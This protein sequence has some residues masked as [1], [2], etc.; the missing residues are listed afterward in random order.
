MSKRARLA[1]H[2]HRACVVDGARAAVGQLTCKTC[3][4]TMAAT[5]HEL[6]RQ[7]AELLA[8]HLGGA[9]NEKLSGTTEPPIPYRDPIGNERGRI[10]TALAGWAGG[11]ARATG[12]PRPVDRHPLATAGYLLDHHTWIQ[13]WAGVDRLA[14]DLTAR[15]DA[16]H[17]LLFPVGQ[18]RFTITMPD[19]TPARCLDCAGELVATIRH[20][21]D[22]LPSAITC[23]RC[24]LDIPASS[25]LTW[26][27]QTRRAMVSTGVMAADGVAGGG[28]G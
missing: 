5:M 19:G 18:R 23:G 25:W 9:S 11:V 12:D 22:L 16:A 6:P 10:V 15:R 1:R 21:D 4:Q 28:D 26:A 17:A 13:Q 27:R 3:A 7:W 2:A 20:T 14:A 8:R 24:Q